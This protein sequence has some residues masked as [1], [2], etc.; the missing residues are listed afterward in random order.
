MLV[1]QRVRG[2]NIGSQDHD[3][4]LAK[5]VIRWGTKPW[6]MREQWFRL[7]HFWL[8]NITGDGSTMFDI[9]NMTLWV[10]RFPVGVEGDTG[11]IH[12]DTGARQQMVLPLQL[13]LGLVVWQEA[14]H[15]RAF[16][17]P[18]KI[19]AGIQ[20]MGYSVPPRLIVIH[21]W[22]H[23]SFSD[24]PNWAVAAWHLCWFIFTYYWDCSTQYLG[25]LSS[26][27]LAILFLTELNFVE[28]HFCCR[29]VLTLPVGSRG[30][31]DVMGRSCKAHTVHDDPMFLY[32]VGHHAQSAQYTMEG[33]HVASL[34]AVPVMP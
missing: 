15:G 8:R 3:Q 19:Q 4:T 18:T 16:W 27:G 14:R 6:W 28:W 11:A 34:V 13:L 5:P 22:G 21:F 7:D 12:G 20:Q 2:Q 17:E 10:T 29:K 1:Y 32:T 33:F 30:H 26:T 31:G 25:A 23:T 9:Q 24:K